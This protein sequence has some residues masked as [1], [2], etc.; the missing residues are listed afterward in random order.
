[1]RPQE[2]TVAHG[3]IFFLPYLKARKLILLILRTDLHKLKDTIKQNNT[4]VV[5]FLICFIC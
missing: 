2:G 4:K 5:K 1:M 3:L